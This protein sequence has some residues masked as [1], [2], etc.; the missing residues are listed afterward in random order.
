MTDHKLVADVLSAIEGDLYRWDQRE[1]VNDCGT[2]MC[3]GGWALYL[4]GYQ[5]VL[6]GQR[7]TFRSPN[8]DV[9]EYASDVEGEAA[10]ILG[11]DDNAAFQ[12]F[13]WQPDDHFDCD[14]EELPSKDVQFEA[15]KAHVLAVTST[16]GGMHEVQ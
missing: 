4:R 3:F 14:P 7:N 5:P 6:C 2:Q 13:H 16:E 15:F 10:D 12:V 11:F 8:G 9:I 1:Y